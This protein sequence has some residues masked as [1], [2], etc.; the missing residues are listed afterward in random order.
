MSFILMMLVIKKS[1]V[2]FGVVSILV[3][4]IAL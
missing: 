4:D 1:Y 3:N 2:L